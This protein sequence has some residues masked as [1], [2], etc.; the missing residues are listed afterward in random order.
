MNLENIKPGDEVICIS[1]YGTRS[2][3]KV[4]RVTKTQIIL[5]NNQKFRKND[6]IRI[7]RQRSF[8]IS[9]ITIPTKDEKKEIQRDNVIRKAL[10][11][12]HDKEKISYD[13]A[14]KI[15]EILEK[16]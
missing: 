2:I 11:L 7:G 5:T 9:R 14:I 6:G 4:D 15:I 12:M 13:Q 10:V 16:E 3:E 1:Y 8:Y